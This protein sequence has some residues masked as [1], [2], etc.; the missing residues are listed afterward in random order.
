MCL[1]DFKGRYGVEYIP[2]E[3]FN[4]IVGYAERQHFIEYGKL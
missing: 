1:H 3:F 4:L 2:C